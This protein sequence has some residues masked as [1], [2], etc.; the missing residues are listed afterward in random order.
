MQKW[1]KWEAAEESDWL[2]AL[3]RESGLS[4]LAHWP[5]SRGP[6]RNAWKR[7]HWSS[8]CGAASN[9]STSGFAFGAR[10]IR[11]RQATILAVPQ[12]VLSSGIKVHKHQRIPG[13]KCSK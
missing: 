8:V 1:R 9:V 3:K 5:H 7:P 6:V 4:P 12:H 13:F 10:L 11:A 2:M